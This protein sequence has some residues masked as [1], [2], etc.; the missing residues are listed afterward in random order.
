MKAY[1]DDILFR[2]N[3]YGEAQSVINSIEKLAPPFLTLN[4]SKCGISDLTNSTEIGKSIK[5][6]PIVISYRY[7]GIN[8]F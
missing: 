7:L 1:A 5:A 2:V 8:L 3:I 4:K 6:I